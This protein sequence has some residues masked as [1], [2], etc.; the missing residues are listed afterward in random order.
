MSSTRNWFPSI[1]DIVK[2]KVCRYL[3]HRYLGSY[4]HEKISLD[5]L[6]VDFYNG[7]GTIS[8]IVLSPEVC[9][10]SLVLKACGWGLSWHGDNEPSMES[11]NVLCA[12]F[13]YKHFTSK[14]IQTCQISSMTS[15]IKRQLTI[16]R[17]ADEQESKAFKT[18]FNTQ[19][20]VS[21]QIKDHTSRQL[22]Y[23]TVEDSISFSFSF[24]FFSK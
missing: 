2:K 17:T 4:I 5:Q 14:Y 11:S 6:N 8:D 20:D 23:K 1:T 19:K 9:K 12:K 16:G 18:L 7:K 22:Q 3:L 10:Y 15:Q 21:S 13:F 24:F